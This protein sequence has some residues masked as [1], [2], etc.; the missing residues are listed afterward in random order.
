MQS[1]V[2][3]QTQ[4]RGLTWCVQEADG[5]MSRH[6]RGLRGPRAGRW[7]AP[8]DRL[9]WAPPAGR[10]LPTFHLRPRVCPGVPVSPQ[11]PEG[12]STWLLATVNQQTLGLHVPTLCLH[13]GMSVSHRT[14][15]VHIDKWAVQA[16]AVTVIAGR[17]FSLIYG[18]LKFSSREKLGHRFLMF[19]RGSA[20]GCNHLA[21]VLSPMTG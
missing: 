18:H 1:R 16:S 14:G 13:R 12:A 7:E 10:A 9:P 8:M 3:C 17:I 4:I 2:F 11:G 15:E 20:V 19:P 6:W 5:Y 21:S